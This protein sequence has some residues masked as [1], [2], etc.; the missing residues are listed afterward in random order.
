MNASAWIS[1]AGI[2]VSFISVFVSNWLGR[3]A[4]VAEM[5]NNQRLKRY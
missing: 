3:K 2:L 1:L 4:A 5:G